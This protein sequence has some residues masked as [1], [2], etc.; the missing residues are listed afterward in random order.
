MNQSL[1]DFI[2]R[3]AND[4]EKEVRVYVW[5]SMKSS[6]KEYLGKNPMEINPTN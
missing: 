5:F 4:S 6:E 3:K 2:Q 1:F